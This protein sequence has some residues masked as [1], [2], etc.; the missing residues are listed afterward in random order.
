MAAPASADQLSGPDPV[1]NRMPIV[2]RIAAGLLPIAAMTVEQAWRSVAGNGGR[3]GLA[4]EDFAECAEGVGVSEDGLA[5]DD[6]G[7]DG[8]MIWLR[9]RP[10]LAAWPFCGARAADGSPS[11]GATRVAALPS[12]ST[13]NREP[14]TTSGSERSRPAAR[15]HTSA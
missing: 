8:G 9:G 7:S 10:G 13:Q 5:S 1:S 15:P 14:G 11:G 6:A 2:T 4:A 3:A 12:C